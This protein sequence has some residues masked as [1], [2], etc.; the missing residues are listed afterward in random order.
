MIHSIIGVFLAN[1]HKAA[2]DSNMLVRFEGV[3]RTNCHI[4]EVVFE[5][6]FWLEPIKKTQAKYQNKYTEHSIL[7]NFV[8]FVVGIFFLCYN[9]NLNLVGPCEYMYLHKI[10][11]LAKNYVYSSPCTVKSPLCCCCCCCW[12]IQW[13]FFEYIIDYNLCHICFLQFSSHSSYSYFCSFIWTASNFVP[14]LSVKTK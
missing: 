6:K 9:L 2:F 1:L 10:N 13:I 7:S 11:K 8:L 5:S 3:F 12:S 14:I 4:P